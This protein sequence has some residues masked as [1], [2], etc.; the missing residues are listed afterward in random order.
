QVGEASLKGL[1]AG[2]RDE[3]H[4]PMT[5]AAQRDDQP[6][7]LLLSGVVLRLS[8]RSVASLNLPEQRQSVRILHPERRQ[9]KDQDSRRG[10]LEPLGEPGESNLCHCREWRRSAARTPDG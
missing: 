10:K 1:A 8:A 2:T 7:Y 3:F 5:S 9:D 6:R 4:A